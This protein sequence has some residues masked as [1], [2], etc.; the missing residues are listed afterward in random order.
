MNFLKPYKGYIAQIN[1]D[2]DACIIHG[3]VIGLKDVI[4]FNGESVQ[5]VTQAF[6]RAVDGYLAV[7]EELGEKPEK[8]FSGKIFFRTKP[9]VHQMICKAAELEG[10]SISAWMGKVLAIEAERT[11]E[12][13]AK[14]PTR[15]S[16]TK[17]IPE[18][19]RPS[20]R[21]KVGT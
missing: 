1:M 20:V 5:E 2:V 16:T 8:T 10:T 14:E 12:T 18:D 7:C 6:H 19:S 13:V 15:A 11:I 9:Q 17:S 4:S 3:R 21:A